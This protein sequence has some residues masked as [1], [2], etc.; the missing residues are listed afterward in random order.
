MS[1]FSLRLTHKIAAIGIA[2]V[3]GVVLVGGIHFYGESVQASFRNTATSARSLSELNRKVNI[4]LLEGRRAEKD[5]LLRND[6]KKAESQIEF[7]KI[8]TADIEALREKINGIG[9]PDLARQIDAMS[10][11]LKQYQ[12]HFMS[13]VEQKKKLGLDEKSGLE[14]RLRASV[15][16]IE[17]Q[18]AEL[19]DLNLHDT[20]LMMRRH[21]KDFMLRRDRKYGDEMKSEASKFAVEIESANIPDAARATLK[22]KLGDY[23][24]DFFAWMDTALALAAELTATS[25]SFS[26]VEPIIEAISKEVDS[27]STEA[28]RSN[29]S[30][31]D[32]A[33]LE[34]EI[35]I[36]LI[37]LIVMSASFVIARFGIVKP[38]AELVQD[39]ERLS[40]GDTSVEFKT[41]AR[42]D[43]IG[44]VASAVAKFRDNVIA[45]Q[46]AAKSFASEIEAREVLKRD[47]EGAVEGFRISAN[48]LLATV[49]ENAGVMKQTAEALTVQRADR[50]GRRRTAH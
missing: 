46:Q 32:S 41:A 26:T 27:V 9:K 23:Q 44:Q 14:S 16:D 29:I 24:R 20:M 15:H 45:Q 50:G 22:Q 1:N 11:S 4:E 35:V 49:G 39:S 43:E 6:P 47:M 8:V 31:R 38:L 12:A 42:G 5:F 48:E 13:V 30:A 18:V 2:G 10:T 34:M 3:L 17:T 21:E 40:A 7:N 37:A 36:L 33:Q 28:E 25:E 19:H